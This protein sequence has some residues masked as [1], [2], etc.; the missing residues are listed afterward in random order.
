M[1]AAVQDE[2]LARRAGAI[3]LLVLG[4]AVL[5]FVVLPGRI[6]LGSPIRIQ[7]MFR[8]TAG[9]HERG[10]LVVAGQPIGRI[11][12]IAPVGHSSDGPLAGEI[13]A[14]VTIAIRRRD[15]WKVPAS[16]AIFVASRGPL[17]D[18]YLEVAPSTGEPGAAIHDGQ[19]LRGIDPP[20]LD[21]VMQH[22]WANLT[23]FQ[24]FVAT[25]R[26]ELSALTSQLGAL[27]S[28]LDGIANGPGAVGGLMADARAAIAAART[29]YGRARWAATPG[30]W[31]W[32]RPSSRRARRSPMPAPP[33]IGSARGPP[34]SPPASVAWAVRS[35]PPRRSRAPASYSRRSAPISTRSI[36]GWPRWPSWATGSR[37]VRARSAA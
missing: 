31:R 15:A 11:E 16:A 6:D 10:P 19:V 12:T 34:R 37:A 26:P 29:T 20:S 23:A 7:V 21:N 28:Q 35:A 3:T 5:G 2:R 27:R 9:L 36:R 1:S 22:T 18:K 13:G 4:S 25:V 24:R 30:P 8:A 14:S 33:S 17:A 32:A